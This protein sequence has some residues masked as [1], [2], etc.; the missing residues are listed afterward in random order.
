ML[1][2][3]GRCFPDA[4]S[5]ARAGPFDSGIERIQDVTGVQL[6]VV[7]TRAVDGESRV[8]HSDSGLIDRD[9]QEST[10]AGRVAPVGHHM[11]DMEMRRNRFDS[12]DEDGVAFPFSRE[13][14]RP[15]GVQR[16]AHRIL[17]CD[18][19]HAVVS[20][21]EHIFGQRADAGEEALS[22]GQLAGP[23]RRRGARTMGRAA[24]AVGDLA[25][26]RLLCSRRHP[27]RARK[28]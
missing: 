17:I 1:Q 12:R 18:R 9:R 28:G 23:E 15:A 26:E 13:L 25:G 20:I 21:D 3:A 10:R 19:Q 27:A 8:Q 6:D 5:G 14:H 24:H 11:A 7:E 22:I 2:R 4:V 16:K